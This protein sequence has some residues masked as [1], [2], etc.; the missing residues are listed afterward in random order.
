MDGNNEQDVKILIVFFDRINYFN[1]PFFHISGASRTIRRSAIVPFGPL[2][3][4]CPT[5][6]STGLLRCILTGPVAE[7]SEALVHYRIHGNNLSSQNAISGLSPRRI[8][9]QCRRDIRKAE[10]LGYISVN[11]AEVFKNKVNARL[12]RTLLF[13]MLHQSS[14]LSHWWVL[15]LICL[16]GRVFTFGEKIQI[17]RSNLFRKN[18][19][20]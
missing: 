8:F 7:S 5:E 13:N 17:L 6:D 18:S 20:K 11:I 9:C 12:K 19:A 16:S 2:N 4:L 14:G 3:R 15:C 1:E 10:E